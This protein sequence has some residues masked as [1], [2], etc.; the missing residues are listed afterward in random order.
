[1]L[2]TNSKRIAFRKWRIRKIKRPC[3]R[4]NRDWAGQQFTRSTREEMFLLELL[5]NKQE[6][7]WQMCG[8]V[9]R[10]CFA[11]SL[12]ACLSVITCSAARSAKSCV[13]LLMCKHISN[14]FISLF[15]FWLSFLFLISG[16][17]ATGLLSQANSPATSFRSAA[18]SEAAF[19]RSRVFISHRRAQTDRRIIKRK[20]AFQRGSFEKRMDPCGEWFL[21]NWCTSGFGNVQF[22]FYPGTKRETNKEQTLSC[23]YMHQDLQKSYQLYI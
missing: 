21:V 14:R 2:S 23:W 18:D 4:P 1:M 6:L 7:T 20:P 17:R 16:E 9:C 3:S 5:P 8:Y 19:P 13:Y 22:Y 15:F 10:I 12:P 11:W